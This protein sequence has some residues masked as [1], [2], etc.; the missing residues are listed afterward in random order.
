MAVLERNPH[1]KAEVLFYS[2]LEFQVWKNKDFVQNHMHCFKYPP[3]VGIKTLVPFLICR[4]T[5]E[6]V[7]NHR[8]FSRYSLVYL[9]PFVFVILFPFTLYFVSFLFHSFIYIYI[10]IYI[11]VFIQCNTSIQ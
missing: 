6:D 10:Y 3:C 2:L 8:I 5:N 1:S 7:E 11:G 9:L 4:V